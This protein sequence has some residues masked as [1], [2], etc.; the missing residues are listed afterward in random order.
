MKLDFQLSARAT[1]LIER[2]KKKENEKTIALP[3]INRWDSL[4]LWE[5]GLKFTIYPSNATQLH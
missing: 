2:K 4:R 3:L 1:K 5:T